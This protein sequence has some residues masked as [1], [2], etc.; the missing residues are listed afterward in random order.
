MC[1]R[2]HPHLEGTDPKINVDMVGG[3]DGSQ[4][5]PQV[6]IGNPNWVSL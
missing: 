1:Q 4:D 5:L 3:V 2:G 6:S